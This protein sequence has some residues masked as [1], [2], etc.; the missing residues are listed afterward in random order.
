MSRGIIA[1]KA[2]VL[3]ALDNDDLQKGIRASQ[4]RL[5]GMAATAKG[6]GASF[7]GV[8]AA[9]AGSLALAV[10]AASDSQEIMNKFK[11]VF[12]ENTQAVKKWG[13]EFS[14]RIGRSKSEVQ[15][16]L[17]SLQDLFVPLGF[18]AEEATN[19]SKQVSQLTVDLASFNNK[20]DADVLRDLQAAMTGSGEVMKKYGVIVSEAAVKQEL[21]NQGLDPKTVTDQQK[22][23]ARLNIIMRGTTA[24]QGDAERSGASFANQMKRLTGKVD[25]LL[26][27][28]GAKLLPVLETMTDSVNQWLPIAEKWIEDNE[29]LVPA[30]VAVA[31]GA[32]ALGGT[33]I[34]LGV[35]AGGLSAALGVLGAV[36]GALTSPF[37]LGVA[38]GIALG[39]AFLWATG[40]LEEIT[41]GFGDT[42][43][44]MSRA[45]Q[46]GGIETAW[47]TMWISMAAAANDAIAAVLES[48]ATLV[49]S[50]TKNK[51]LRV[52]LNLGTFGAGG[53]LGDAASGGLRGKANSLR[54]E[55]DLIRTARD[56]GLT[57]LESQPKPVN[58]SAVAQQAIESLGPALGLSTASGSASSPTLPA[59]ISESI[60]NVSQ[61]I[62]EPVTQAAGA[63][64]TSE[65]VAKQEET[66][67]L[68]GAIKTNTARGAVWA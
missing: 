41:A 33:L 27:A 50:I 53:A 57:Q 47:Q 30:I 65:M 37:V 5:R 11:V 55:A 38:L 40:A 6:I 12:G 56:F 28:I 67:V 46:S 59:G 3:L 51:V 21:L 20:A 42:I 54:S 48:M 31:A 2:S 64:A 36:A 26:G 25:D 1:G 35:V 45:L 24:A 29:E 17:A 68:L 44:A 4:R 32:S 23:M 10:K 62:L 49:E 14:D 39:A 66:N 61:G 7:A 52:A 34:A 13:E 16:M 58:E 63:A 15:G 60:A 19:M 43:K 22:V 8:G 18:S 9:A